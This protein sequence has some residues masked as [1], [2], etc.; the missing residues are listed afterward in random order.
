MKVR[1]WKTEDKI[2]RYFIK[3][4]GCNEEHQLNTGWKFNGDIE[5]PTF[6]PSLHVFY[7]AHDGMPQKTIC[8]SFIRDGKIQFLN[9]CIHELK[10]KT[11]DL[12][13]YEQHT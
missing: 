6:H 7:P 4:P 12:P 9:D 10:G 1:I 3:C 8:H 11:V 2:H 13:N 5:K